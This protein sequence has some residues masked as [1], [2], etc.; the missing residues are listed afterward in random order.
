[1][2][3]SE[4]ENARRSSFPDCG[5]GGKITRILQEGK[6]QIPLTGKRRKAGSLV[7]SGQRCSKQY[8]RW[9]SGKSDNCLVATAGRPVQR[10][11]RCISHRISALH[12]HTKKQTHLSSVCPKH[13]TRLHDNMF[14]TYG[15][16][17][18]LFLDDER[19]RNKRDGQLPL[20]KRPIIW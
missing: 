11:S 7:L 4:T 17:N 1:M 9:P 20:R 8:N 14:S 2:G 12:D 13:L 10:Q 5:F 15:G 6:K 19:D 3:M 18:Q 16:S